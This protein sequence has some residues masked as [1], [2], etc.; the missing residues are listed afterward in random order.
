[1]EHSESCLKCST[2]GCNSQGPELQKELVC[3][4]CN[5]HTEGNG[6]NCNLIDKK[7]TTV[8]CDRP[9]LGY[10]NVCYTYEN[11]DDDPIRGCFNNAPYTVFKEC[12]VK[13]ETC[14]TCDESDCNNLTPKN[15]M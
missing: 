10:K 4:N 15:Q 9:P 11:G 2:R 3:A 12:F 1:M 13:N 14:H 8:K 6:R 7:Y 5:P